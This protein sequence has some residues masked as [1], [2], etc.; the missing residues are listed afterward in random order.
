MIGVK[1]GSIVCHGK[2]EEVMTKQNLKNI[3]NIDAE[4]VMDPRNNKPVC[5]TYD[6][7]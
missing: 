2:P 7:V 5:I 3:F 4:I 1:E 6:L